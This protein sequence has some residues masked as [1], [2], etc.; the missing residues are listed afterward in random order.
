MKPMSD[1]EAVAQETCCDAYQ[2]VGFLAHA[3]GYWEMSANDPRQHQITKL[4]DNLQAAGEGLPL[5]HSDLLPF[6]W[7]LDG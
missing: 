7:E 5:P 6:G 4:L 3:L 2:A 1:S